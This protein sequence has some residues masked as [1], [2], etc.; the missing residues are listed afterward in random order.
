[1]IQ[2]DGVAARQRPLVLASVSVTWEAGVHS[3]LGTRADGGPLLCALVAG[4]LRP[5][6]GAIRVLRGSPYDAEI[7]KQIA[8]VPLDAALPDALRV[9]ESLAM[10][11]A[12]RGEP[13]RPAAERLARLGI[14]SLATRRVGSLSRPEARAVA[15]AE[16]V[17]SSRVRVLLVE[18]PYAAMD[19]R[20]CARLGACLRTLGEEGRAVV[21]DTASARD[22]AE[23]ADDH[24][25]LR[26]GTVL[27][28]TES[29][30]DL[31]FGPPEGA[32]I[33]IVAR[34]EDDG[35]VI[36]IAL[37]GDADVQSVERRGPAVIAR[38][39]NASRLAQAAERAVVTAARDVTEI[40]VD[41][42]SLDDARA[43]TSEPGP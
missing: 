6:S 11:A 31:A 20:A 5:R 7:R 10:A 17:T 29:L 4:I 22:A 13:E 8:R 36:G 14:E 25:L 41:P 32:R 12:I 30:D 39:R 19:P 24:L 27:G 26:A 3:I 23:L 15:L 38:G 18:E 1:M 34:D 35:R 9:D 21:V 43:R 37:A 2:L 40:R 16:A 28:R 33:R 42:P